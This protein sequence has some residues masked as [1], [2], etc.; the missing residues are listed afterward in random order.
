VEIDRTYYKAYNNLGVAYFNKNFFS[1]AK[2]YFEKAIEINPEYAVA[3]KN[4]EAA[5]KKDVV[6]RE[7][8]NKLQEKLGGGAKERN[9]HYDLANAY[10]NTGQLKEAVVE[11]KK[12]LEISPNDGEVLNKLGMVHFETEDYEAAVRIFI[13]AVSADSKD[14]M[15]HFLLAEAYFK[16]EWWD[17][18]EI[19]YQ[20]SAEI[21]PSM[22]EALFKL[23]EV[24]RRKGWWEE[25]IEM[26]KAYILKNPE[27]ENARSAQESI[28]MVEVWKKELQLSPTV[29]RKKVIK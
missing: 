21:D 4:L 15:S 24:Y 14:P 5:M 1:E 9:L 19:E 28:R 18:A 13:D 29:S 22:T 3:R 20:N 11:Y 8:I 10:R 7:T 23:G 26:W 27:S 12:A 6:F 25:A 17:E 2:K 16:K